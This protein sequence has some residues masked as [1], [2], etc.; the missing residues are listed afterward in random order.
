[1]AYGLHCESFIDGRNEWAV[2]AVRVPARN[3][4][5]RRRVVKFALLSHSIF[6]R[7][8]DLDDGNDQYGLEPNAHH[9][10]PRRESVSSD[11]SNND[12]WT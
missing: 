11:A 1:M 12:R 5:L 3:F 6:R 8:S 7:Q 9:G 4:T 2:D 10:R